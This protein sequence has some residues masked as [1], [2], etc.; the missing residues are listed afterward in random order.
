MRERDL[1]WGGMATFAMLHQAEELV[2]LAQRARD[3]AQPADMLR[4]VPPGVVA[5]A[6]GV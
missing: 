3:R 2:V 5:P 1:V 6:V 4:V